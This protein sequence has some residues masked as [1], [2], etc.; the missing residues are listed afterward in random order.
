MPASNITAI[1]IAILLGAG[2]VYLVPAPPP[3][4]DEITQP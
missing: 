1:V 3:P 4:A 2:V